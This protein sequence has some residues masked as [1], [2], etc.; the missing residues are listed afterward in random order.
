MNRDQVRRLKT[1]DLLMTNC[2]CLMYTKIYPKY[3]IEGQILKVER[4]TP[5]LFL[6]KIFDDDFLYVRTPTHTGWL[7]R[8]SIEPV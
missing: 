2:Q 5:V 1:G 3:S 7:N 4:K 6:G 8:E